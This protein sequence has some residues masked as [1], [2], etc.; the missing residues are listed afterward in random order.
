M[1][2]IAVKVCCIR[3]LNVC[4]SV[5]SLGGAFCPSKRITEREDRPKRVKDEQIEIEAEPKDPEPDIPFVF[6]PGVK[7]YPDPPPPPRPDPLPKPDPPYIIIPP[8]DFVPG[9][10]PGPYPGPDPEPDPPDPIPDDEKVCVPTTYTIIKPEDVL[11]P[12]TLYDYVG[13]QT[14]QIFYYGT[15]IDSPLWQ[16]FIEFSFPHSIAFV[17]TNKV[18]YSS[19]PPFYEITTSYRHIFDAWWWVV[20]NCG[21][22]Y[23][24]TKRLVVP[25]RT[26]MTPPPIEEIPEEIPIN[27]IFNPDPEGGPVYDD[28]EVWIWS[29]GGPEAPPTLM[30]N[31]VVTDVY[32]TVWYLPAHTDVAQK[33]KSIRTGSGQVYYSQLYK[34]GLVY[35]HDICMNEWRLVY[36]RR[37]KLQR[38]GI[39]GY[40]D[41]SDSGQVDLFT[42]RIEVIHTPEEDPEAIVSQLLGW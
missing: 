20:D 2:E 7:F 32:Q 42:V 5:R 40:L 36:H 9:P 35:V 31:L 37:P 16:H 27:I 34:F 1:Q 21:G 10:G 3:I 30:S 18:E 33:G 22:E 23:Q 19:G 4:A 38:V 28:V 26:T 13:Q 41:G 6:I 39:E 12:Y 17:G 24:I 29:E 15:V 8:D 11:D 25:G 14:G